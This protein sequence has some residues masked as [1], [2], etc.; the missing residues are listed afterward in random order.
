MEKQINEYLVQLSRT[1]ISG[2]YVDAVCKKTLSTVKEA[3]AVLEEWIK[4]G[5]LSVRYILTHPETFDLEKIYEKL[6]DIPFGEYYDESPFGDEF[7]IEMDLM[8]VQY[9]FTPEQKEA[10]QKNERTSELL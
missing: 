5:K 8:N 4:E 1:K 6:E 10:L 3:T 2:F 9:Y 7:R